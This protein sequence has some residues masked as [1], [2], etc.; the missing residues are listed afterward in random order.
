MPRRGFLRGL[1]SLPLIGGSAALIGQPTAVAQPVTPDLL[2][3]YKAFLHFEY[4]FLTWEMADDPACLAR[5]RLAGASRI[6]RSDVIANNIW[7]IFGDSAR[8]YGRG[9]AT[10]RAALVLGAIDCDWRKDRR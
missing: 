5:Y 3:A 1:A 4:R 7:E 6:E 8:M 2:E 9:S 10:S